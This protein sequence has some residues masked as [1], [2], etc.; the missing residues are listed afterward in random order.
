MYCII[1]YSKL[2]QF[3]AVLI[4]SEIQDADIINNRRVVKGSVYSTV[5]KS[6][7]YVPVTAHTL[8]HQQRLHQLQ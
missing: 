2:V 5:A 3:L 7:A 6:D 4:V 8:R 1:M